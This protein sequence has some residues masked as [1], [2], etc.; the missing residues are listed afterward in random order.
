MKVGLDSIG[1]LS[2]FR[3]TLTVNDVKKALL[4]RLEMETDVKE[5]Y[6]AGD[7]MTK[8]LSGYEIAYIGGA[9]N[10]EVTHLYCYVVLVIFVLFFVFVVCFS[11]LYFF[12]NVVILVLVVAVVVVVVVVVVY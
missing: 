4:Y 12:F 1:C 9:K 8:R 10:Y 2:I 11:L 3:I 6:Q 5:R 7:L